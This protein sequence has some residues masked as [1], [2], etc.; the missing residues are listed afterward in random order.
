MPDFI[1]QVRDGA[2]ETYRKY[3]VLPSITVAQAALESGWGKSELVHR[4]AKITM[5]RLLQPR[6]TKRQRG[7]CSTQ[8]MRQIPAMRK[9]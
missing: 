1:E 7:R 6:T 4:G 8:A 3:G 2:I 5:L 9:S